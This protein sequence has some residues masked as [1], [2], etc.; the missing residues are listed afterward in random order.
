MD[1]EI[2]EDEMATGSSSGEKSERLKFGRACPCPEFIIDGVRCG[3]SSE[4]GYRVASFLNPFFGLRR[5][6]YL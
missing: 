3:D 4:K 1:D 6:R 2:E 5:G